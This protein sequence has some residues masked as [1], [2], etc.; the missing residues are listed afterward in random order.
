M[1]SAGTGGGG[2]CESVPVVRT[3][4]NTGEEVTKA[5][6]TPARDMKEVG[7][8]EISFKIIFANNDGVSID[9]L[10]NLDMT[11]A[12]TKEVLKEKWPPSMEECP[13]FDRIRLIW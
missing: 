12:E 3:W 7:E 6:V 5:V 8:G 13:S 1:D 2:D 11:L 10:V 4:S 9:I